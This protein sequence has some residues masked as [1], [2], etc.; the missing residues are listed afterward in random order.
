MRNRLRI[1]LFSS[2]TFKMP[3]KNNFLCL[4]LFEG[5]FTSLFKDKKSERSHKTVEIEI[6]LLFFAF[7]DP[8]LDPDPYK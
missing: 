4:F 5:T 6:F 8:D 1:L 7:F 3:T 2:V